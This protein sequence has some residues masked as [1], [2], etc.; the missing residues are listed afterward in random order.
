LDILGFSSEV[1]DASKA[2]N[3]QQHLEKLRAAL[4]EA[5]SRLHTE[6]DLSEFG[7]RTADY[8]VKVFTDN[9]V[10]GIPIQ[11]DGE[12]ELGRMI[13][14][15]GNYQFSLLQRGFFVRGG[16]TVGDLYIDANTVYGNALLDAHDAETQLAR[17]PRIVLD[18]KV[19]ELVHLHLTYY[20]AIKIAPHNEDL[21]V[22]SDTQMFLNYLMIPLYGEPPDDSYFAAFANHRDLIKDRLLKFAEQ[23]Q[24]WSKYVWAGTYHNVICTEF[25]HRPDFAIEEKLLRRPAQ[26]LDKVY[27]KAKHSIFRGDQHVAT[28]KSVFDTKKEQEK[29][30]S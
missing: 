28:W 6:A 30:K 21:L 10:I 26:R 8:M 18:A 20:A 7:I 5:N 14:L 4:E 27:T 1:R 13:D 22:D 3:Q 16:I 25:L 24:L 15:A 17:D 12:S 2:G 11:D 19:M 23:P 9:V 29:K